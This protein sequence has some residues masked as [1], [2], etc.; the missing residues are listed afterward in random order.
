MYIKL[1]KEYM[2]PI[3]VHGKKQLPEDRIENKL[4]KLGWE[5]NPNYAK[6][7]CEDIEELIQ[8]FKYLEKLNFRGG[9]VSWI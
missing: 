5:I 6:Y 1:Y 2:S 9:E 8:M 3:G 7:E 4:L